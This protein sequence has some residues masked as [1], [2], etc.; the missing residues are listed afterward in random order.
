MV[1]VK[2][3]GDK[4]LE[5]VSS[6]K[7]MKVALDNSPNEE[8]IAKVTPNHVKNLFVVSV[9]KTANLVRLCNINKLEGIPDKCYLP[10]NNR[11]ESCVI[12]NAQ[13]SI[14]EGNSKKY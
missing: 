13:Q 2:P 11:A 8:G 12:L 14:R 10:F 7:T 9:S 1:I 6:S 5:L 4:G 3:E